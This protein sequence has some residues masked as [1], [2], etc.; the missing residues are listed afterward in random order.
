MPRFC[1][2]I[3]AD[4]WRAGHQEQLARSYAVEYC[5]T[6]PRMTIKMALMAIGLV[7][8]SDLPAY[9]ELER[10]LDERFAHR[11]EGWFAEQVLQ[12]HEEAK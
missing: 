2:W 9:A 1:S 3:S 12:D 5:S 11:G 10:L 4:T 6:R 7:A 8:Y